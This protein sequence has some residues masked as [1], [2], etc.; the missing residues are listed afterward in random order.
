MEG[1]AHFE[2]KTQG[3]FLRQSGQPGA[4]TPCS[5]LS[6]VA[7]ASPAQQGLG[8]HPYTLAQVPPWGTQ[9]DPHPQT[10]L[11]PQEHGKGETHLD[12]HGENSLAVTECLPK[13]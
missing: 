5:C 3:G 6:I 13:A 11:A 9:E 2:G 12:N 4:H 10:S 8:C 7:L 1:S